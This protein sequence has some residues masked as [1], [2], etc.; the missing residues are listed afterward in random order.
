MNNKTLRVIARLDVKGKNLIKGVNLE[1]LR[2]IG[3][4]NEFALKYYN[5]N[6][7][8]I[9]Y[10]DP[11]ASLYERSILTDIVKKTC[12]EVFVPITVGGGIKSLNDVE[13][14]LRSGAD[15]V[16]INTSI[17][18]NPLLIN[19]ISKRFGS[20]CMVASI[21]VKKVNDTWEIFT[22]SGREKTGIKVKEWVDTVQSLGAGEILITSID[23]EGTKKGFD[24]DLLHHISD[25]IKLPTIISGGFG[26]LGDLEIFNL[27]DNID[28]IAIA[29]GLHYNKFT[30]NQI[31]KKI[32]EN[33]GIVRL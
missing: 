8:E 9:L 7:D 22:L 12:K 4:P 5:E 21:E 27:I 1:G 20:Q 11:V 23:K 6:A 31:K 30:I 29:D 28:A 26:N 15:K 33:Y 18:K 10:I 14:I 24:I 16:A 25:V 2:V 17:V 3:D 19:D 32:S 13:K